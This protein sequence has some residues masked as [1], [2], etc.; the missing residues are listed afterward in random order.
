MPKTFE[1]TKII[2]PDWHVRPELK[3]IDFQLCDD[4][5]SEAWS[6]S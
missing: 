4:T 2:T 6:Q 3:L 1:I 5:V